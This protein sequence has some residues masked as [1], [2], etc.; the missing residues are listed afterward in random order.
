M[1]EAIV[2]CP[3]EALSSKLEVATRAT[4]EISIGRVLNFYPIGI[5]LS[6]VVREHAPAMV[7]LSFEQLAE[8]LEVVRFLEVEAEGVQIVAIGR[9]MD[10]KLLREAMR[11]GVREFLA[12]PFTRQALLETITAVKGLFVRKP[13]THGATDQTFAFLPAKPGVGASTIAL[14]ISA[15]MARRPDTHVVLADFDLSCGLMRFMLKLDNEYSVTDAL[16]NSAQM[17]ESLWPKMITTR[18]NLSVLHSGCVNPSLRVETS[19]VRALID[20]LRHKYQAV[21]FDLS[22]NMERYAL[23]AMQDCKRILLVCTPEI[24]SLQ[25]AREKLVYLASCGLD[26]RV[27]VI[28]N[29]TQKKGAFSKEQSEEIL[30]VPVRRCLPNHYVEVTRA[31]AAGSVVSPR[32]DLG[33]AFV[34]FARELMEDR[35]I[36]EPAASKKKFLKFFGI[37]HLGLAPH[38]T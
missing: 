34:Q 37:P 17:D 10:Q 31:I 15:A 21:C 14:N 38:E 5:D 29:R 18:D 20:F 2:I 28:L 11:I 23:E 12:E 25:L 6:R 33:E 13:S 22:G 26:A 24:S 27:S 7:F 36:A 4:G 16:E 32:T 3:D 35:Q 8:A 9:Q 1:L 19:Q 30:G